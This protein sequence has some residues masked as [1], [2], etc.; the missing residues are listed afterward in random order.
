MSRSKITKSKPSSLEGARVVVFAAHGDDEV[1]GCGGTILLHGLAGAE[2]SIVIFADG[3]TSR[4]K[5]ATGRVAQREHSIRKAAAVLGARNVF[6][7]Q[8]PDNQLDTRPLLELAKLVE[9]HI[10]QFRPDTIYTHHP[11]DLNV[12]HR[13]VSQAVVTACRPQGDYSVRR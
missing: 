3:E 11:G 9:K 10:V 6:I 1:L 7:H 5:G 2:V 4:S 8:L 13:Q 12:D